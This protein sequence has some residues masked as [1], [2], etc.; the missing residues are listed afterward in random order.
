M[1]CTNM[2]TARSAK[3]QANARGVPQSSARPALPVRSRRARLV[4]QAAAAVEAPT[5]LSKET[6]ERCVNSI[7]FL[8]EA[9]DLSR[10]S[11]PLTATGSLIG[12][13]DGLAALH[14]AIDG[15]NKAKSGHPGLPMG[16]APMAYVLYNGEATAPGHGMQ[17]AAN[18]PACLHG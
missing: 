11:E 15:V 12:G 13:A 9:A 14:A 4:A 5:K 16:A 3:A 18:A 7:R 10:N 2:Q 6:V 1:Q 8:G 17:L